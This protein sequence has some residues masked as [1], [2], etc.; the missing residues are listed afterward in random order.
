MLINL[1]S[2]PRTGSVWYSY[3]LQRKNLPCVLLSE[4]FNRYHMDLYYLIHPTG[5]IENLHHYVPNS[6]YKEYFIKEGKL[7]SK[8]LY[9][10][11]IRS[12]PEEE[13][14][15]HSLLREI[16]FRSFNYVLHNHVA[17]MNNQIRDTLMELG[18]NIFIYRKDKLAQLASYAIANETREYVSFSKPNY[19]ESIKISVSNFSPIKDLV[20]RIKIWDSLQ[21]EN[22]IAYE[23]INFVNS[24]GMPV[25]Q[26]EDYR[27]RLDERSLKKLEKILNEEYYSKEY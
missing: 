9:E 4:M 3:Y 12:I 21:K 24:P 10:K 14:Y 15:L 27:N 22:I 13:Y 19:K 1:W 2:T 17:P 8:N 25:K 5:K 16:D 11:R 26:N 20:K 18:K 6:F 23:D 7:L